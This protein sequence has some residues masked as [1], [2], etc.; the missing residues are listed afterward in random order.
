MGARRVSV[1]RSDVEYIAGLARLR[2]SG[3][4]AERLTRELNGILEHVASLEEP[5]SGAPGAR[6]VGPESAPRRA[7]GE[8]PADTLIRGPQDFA[9][10]WK[11]GL[12]VV[13]RLPA[14][15]DP[16]PGGP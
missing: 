14:L 3:P 9:P 6:P 12:F 8:V 5:G 1:D 2:L 15:D 16:P 7:P 4:E 11:D 13:P 10:G